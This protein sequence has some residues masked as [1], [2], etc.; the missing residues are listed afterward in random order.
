[1]PPGPILG[2][3]FACPRLLH[4]APLARGEW[5]PLARAEWALLARGEWGLLARGEW[6]LFARRAIYTFGA[7]NIPITLLGSE[8]NLSLADQLRTRIRRDGPISFRDWM[9]VALYDES[10]GYYCR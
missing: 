5:A 7:Q 10:E 9:D 1:M 8:T 2:L 6:G 3:R 4:V